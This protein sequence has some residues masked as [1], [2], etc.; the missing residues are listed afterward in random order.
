[1][2]MDGH[3]DDTNIF[4]AILQGHSPCIRVYEDDIVLAFMD[5]FPESPGHVLVIPKYPARHF[6][7]LPSDQVGPYVARVHMLARAVQRALTPDGIRIMQYNGAEASQTVF[8]VHFHI[9]PCYA[10]QALSEHA[11]QPTALADLQQHADRIKA[12]LA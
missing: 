6:L 9:V 8:H 7:D 12:Q 11:T 3:Y 2:S 5:I 1:M 10:G 4:Q